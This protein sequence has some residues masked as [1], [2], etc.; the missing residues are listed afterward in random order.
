MWLH[1]LEDADASC[2]GKAV[3]LARLIG[4]GLPVPDG[5]VIDD[6]AFRHVVGDLDPASDT[7]GHALTEAARWIT[8]MELPSDLVREVESR[9]AALGAL[10]V[11]SS[12][13]IEDSEAGAGAGVFSSQE[14]VPAADVWMAIR[15]VWMSALTPLAVS[16]ARRRG[17]PIAIGVIVQRF[18]PGELVTIYTRPPSAARGDELVVQ[19]GEAFERTARSAVA[20]SS[21]AAL[22]LRAEAAIGATAGAD[23]EIIEAPQGLWV[24]QARPIVRDV[25]ATRQPAPPPV[26]AALVA[27][28]RRWTW[29]VT[30]NPDPLSPAQAG[31]VEAVERGGVAPWAMRVCAG[32]LYTAARDAA[33]T[34]GE[35]VPPTTVA[36]LEVRVRTIEAAMTAAL[37]GTSTETSGTRTSTNA[38]A[39]A[40]GIAGRIS[41]SE[42]LER[43]V[44]FYAIWAD[45]L[46][47]LIAGCRAKLAPAQLVGARPSAVEATLVAAARDEIG[48]QEVFERLGVMA[49]AW[50]VSVATFA[51]R[52]E[53]VRNAITRAHAFL[54]IN[55]ERFARAREQVVRVRAVDSEHREAVAQPTGG[56]LAQPIGGA[57]A[58]SATAEH[59]LARTA[60]DLA[61]RDDVW[62][63][64]AQWLVRK[65]ILE[66]AHELAIDPDDAFWIPL[67]EVA[68]ATALD[69]DDVHRRASG[70]RAAA[71]RAAQWAMPIIVDGDAGRHDPGGASGATGA[72]LRGIGSGPRVSGR[73]VRF[74][75]LASVVR[76]STGDVVVT[77]AVT[78]ALAVLMIGCAALVSETGGLLDHGAALARELGIPCVV[79]CQDAWQ[80]TNGMVVVVDGDAGTVELSDRR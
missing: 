32:F 7:I 19:R 23:V 74:E 59:D 28:G 66:R 5:F 41:I 78:P 53:L 38:N 54:A 29:D 63:A 4:A 64:R 57:P 46:A 40:L 11:R 50:D 37:E 48:E 42:A 8:T 36:E 3:G 24:V 21:V 60:A 22:A 61:E 68:T 12:A 2:G 70:A 76:V 27:D 79:G 30:H 69:A 47:P 1:R 14:E 71:A 67:E 6:H 77:R 13:T 80:L 72:T 65:A 26:I 33:S 45:E 18:V 39:S 75:T 9:A 62:F 55:R 31:L 51:E 49:P 20:T 16:Y 35:L 10:A 15:M 25:I 73:V 17:G 58:Q 34:E 52:P 56:A 44:A 43:Y